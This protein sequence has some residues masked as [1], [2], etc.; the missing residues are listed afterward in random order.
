VSGHTPFSV[1]GT[2]P[3]DDAAVEPEAV[4]DDEAVPDDAGAADDEVA[5]LLEVI[6]LLEVTAALLEVTAALLDEVAA[7][8]ELVDELDELPQ[9]ASATEATT[10]V[11]ATAI[12]DMGFFTQC[13]CSVAGFQRKGA[14][15]AGR[16]VNR[17]PFS[18]VSYQRPTTRVRNQPKIM[19]MTN[20]SSEATRIVRNSGADCSREV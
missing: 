10:A 14:G 1:V 16:S 2:P 15:T 5:A 11:A 8:D 18:V 20:P 12:R 3:P 7:D 17:Q 9:A 6:A 13:S 19:K 4:A